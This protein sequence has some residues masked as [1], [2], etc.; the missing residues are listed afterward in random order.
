MSD[1]RKCLIDLGVRYVGGTRRFTLFDQSNE[2]GFI[3][4]V[5]GHKYLEVNLVDFRLISET[6]LS[7]DTFPQRCSRILIKR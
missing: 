2:K 4:S 5:S 6:N 1:F 3:P 7:I